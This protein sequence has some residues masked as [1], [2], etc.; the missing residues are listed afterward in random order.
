MKEKM[1]VVWICSV[2][3]PILRSHLDLGFPSWYK[4][5]K[6]ITGKTIREEVA[7][8][9]HWN[10]NAI[11]E[12]EKINEVEL[13]VIFA[14]KQLKKK[15]QRFTD[16]DIHYYAVKE[17][18][19]GLL[20]F[21]RTFLF[22]DQWLY[23]R[24]NRIIAKLVKEINPDLVHMQGAE[25]LAH[26]PS[27]LLLPRTIPCFVQLETM[28]Q[29][30]EARKH[31]SN[32]RLE[33]QRMCEYEVLKRA[34]YLGNKTTHFLQIVRKTLNED[35]IF[36][37]TRLMIGEK[38]DLTMYEKEFDFTYFANYIN[39]SVDLAIEAFGI[40]H[41][42]R[43]ELT[44]DIIGG[45]S[46]SDKATII[47]RLEELNCNDSV[48]IEGRLKTHED[49]IV[50]IK[51]ARFA[52]LPL[53]I[54]VVSGTIREAMWNGL[55][56]ITTH[57]VGTPLLNEKRESVLIS[58]IGDHVAMADNMLKIAGDSQFAELLRKN[59]AITVEEIYGNNEGQAKQWV[60][61]Y[62]A[63]INNFKKGIPLPNEVIF[64]G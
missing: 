53:K 35:V 12:F 5:L 13:H 48:K 59:A 24:S 15:I 20:G 61:A 29:D 25:M 51:K 27:L 44:L 55:P 16:N 52:L 2:S 47:K 45:V 4:F 63:C 64:K 8:Y 50:Q 43:P 22:G 60:S 14:H 1:K 56:V 49:V 57:T 37:N 33:R 42:Q 10:S 54:D 19:Y 28:L 7:D 30:P 46:E 41:R 6:Q 23:N 21:C 40:A 38:G 17:D 36:I 18:E 11:E 9:A 3:N 58:E 39:K 26:S 32:T 31:C 34:D 62:R